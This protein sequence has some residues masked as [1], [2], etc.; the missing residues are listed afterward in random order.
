MSEEAVIRHCSPT[1][2][3]LKT[4]NLFCYQ[5]ESREAMRS[6]LCAWNQ[7]LRGKGVKPQH[8]PI[9]LYHGVLQGSIDKLCYSFHNKAKLTRF[10]F[11]SSKKGVA[12]SAQPNA[13]PNKLIILKGNC[14]L[15][16][17]SV[18]QSASLA[19]SS[20]D[21][22]SPRAPSGIPLWFSHFLA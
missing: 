4:G 13:A 19:K 11:F 9:T 22:V 8:L 1:L 6:A 17:V 2:A 15:S 16:R 3:G 7:R 21:S 5:Y 12:L 18:F 14:Q 20:K 10:L